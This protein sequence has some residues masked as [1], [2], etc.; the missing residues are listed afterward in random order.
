MLIITRELHEVEIHVRALGLD[1][2]YEKIKTKA[3]KDTIIRREKSTWCSSD[4]SVNLRVRSKKTNLE[5]GYLRSLLDNVLTR[6]QLTAI[7]FEH[8][9]GRGV[10]AHRVSTHLRTT[11]GYAQNVRL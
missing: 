6:T 2:Q 4:V 10:R 9:Y 3:S 8:R 5:Y 7:A 11:V 1:T